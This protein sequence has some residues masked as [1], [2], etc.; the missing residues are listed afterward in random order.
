MSVKIIMRD[1]EYEVRPGMN[2]MSALKKLDILPEAVIATRDGDLILEDEILK[3][4]QVIKLVSVI[5]GG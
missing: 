2:L 4:G 3:D 1:K 5:S